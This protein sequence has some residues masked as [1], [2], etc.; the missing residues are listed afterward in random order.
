MGGVKK[1]AIGKE[2]SAINNEH[3]LLSVYEDPCSSTGKR[4]PPLGQ[5]QGLGP[6][7]SESIP[8][9]QYMGKVQK[10]PRQIPPHPPEWRTTEMAVM[11]S[12]GG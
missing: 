11:P 1:Q 2:E 9:A 3:R 8:D 5:R 4:Q 10:N 12:A 7:F 6:A